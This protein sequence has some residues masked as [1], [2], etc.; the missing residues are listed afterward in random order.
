MLIFINAALTG[1]RFSIN[2]EDGDSVELLKEKIQVKE[3][4]LIGQQKLIFTG[5]IMEDKR[6]VKD[7]GVIADST[8]QLVF[9]SSAIPVCL[10]KETFL[11][12]QIG[13][14][15]SYVRTPHTPR[16]PRTP[17]TP[18]M[19]QNTFSPQISP[20]VRYGNLGESPPEILGEF[21]RKNGPFKLRESGTK[22]YCLC[23]IYILEFR[24]DK[25]S[26]DYYRISYTYEYG[27]DTPKSESRDCCWC[28][29]SKSPGILGPINSGNPFISS[30]MEHKMSGLTIEKNEIS[31]SLIR[32]LVMED[33]FLKDAIVRFSADDYRKNIMLSLTTLN[34]IW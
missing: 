9:V 7:Y 27:T 1:K 6:E 21:K 34:R 13:T 8:I 24:D 16:T 33:E 12:S 11:D 20:I 30:E 18:R 5:N 17:L 26:I 22:S 3:G 14:T 2:I 32:H 10:P 15:G 23:T 25:T 28:S 31:T 29:I 19:S 4:I